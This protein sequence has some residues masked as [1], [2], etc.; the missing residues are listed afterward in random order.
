MYRHI[1]LPTDGSALSREA[2]ASAVLFAENISA[3]ITGIHVMSPSHQEHLDAWLHQDDRF[4]QRRKE[5]FERMALDYLSFIANSAL[6]EG[7]PCECKSVSAD[8]PHAAIL[9]EARNS[10]CD[11]IFMASH[12]W[13]D[14][15]HDRIGGETVK[16]L[17]HSTVPVL[18]YRSDSQASHT[19]QR[20]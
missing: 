16:V 13:A 12:G 17:G 2:V 14:A 15:A 20:V 19:A 1:L 10:R 6:A 18:V 4:P 9:A 5:L 3:R 11:L 7:V 8:E